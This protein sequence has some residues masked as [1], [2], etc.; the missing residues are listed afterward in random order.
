MLLGPCC[1][2]VY[3]GQFNIKNKKKAAT[4]MAASMGQ[5]RRE[6]QTQEEAAIPESS[7]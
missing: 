7:S 6:L 1:T 5:A 4:Q 3:I 2:F